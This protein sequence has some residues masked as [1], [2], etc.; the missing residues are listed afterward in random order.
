MEVGGSVLTVEKVK[1]QDL[2]F[3]TP[4]GKRIKA[5]EE[6][7]KPQN[8]KDCQIFSGMLSS[9]STWNP[10]VALEIP[11]IRK[12]TASEGKFVW[13]DEMDREYE[14]VRKTMLE[15]IQLTPFEPN[16]SL[17]LVIDGASTEGAGF[18]LFQWV[19]EM[20]LGD[21]TIIVNAN[22]TRFKESHIWFSPVE[23][24]GIA[25]VFAI[26]CC[27]YW[28][29]YCPRLSCIATIGPFKQTPVRY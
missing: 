21:G 29:S 25:L 17:I 23:A 15:Q 24:E 10:T 19:D 16:K 22:C 3:I 28:I 9:L 14:A 6:L 1:N 5:F 11:M 27:S 20:N 26:S 8:K 18:G 7:R 12:T 13:T 4:R 2:I